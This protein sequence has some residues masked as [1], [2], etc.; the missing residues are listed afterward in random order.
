MKPRIPILSIFVVMAALLL[1]SAFS[2]PEMGPVEETPDAL[3]LRYPDVSGD[4]ITFVYAGDIWVVPKSGGLASR[5]TSAKGNEILPKFSPDGETIAFSGNYDGNVDIYTI[6]RTGG[7]PERLTHHPDDDM[8]VGW[9]PGGKN[10]LFRSNML[11]PSQRYD[12]LFKL[13]AKGGLPEALPLPYG[14]LGSLSP[15]GKKMAF[16]YMAPMRGAWRGYRGGMANDIWIY[17]FETGSIEKITDYPG[18]DSVPMW[19]GKEIY[20]VSDR[21]GEKRINIWA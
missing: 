7:I 18:T 12:R 20:F 11:S 15:D 6:P 19:H 10:I 17:D 8:V 1:G 16:E 9:Y 4:S 13:S 2:N 14:E 5:L 21:G 3:M